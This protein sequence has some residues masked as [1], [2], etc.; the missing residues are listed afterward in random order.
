MASNSEVPHVQEFILGNARKKTD[1]PLNVSDILSNNIN[2][3]IERFRKKLGYDP[4]RVAPKRIMGVAGFSR[5]AVDGRVYFNLHEP[6]ME[7]LR[8]SIGS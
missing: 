4:E 5:H 2:V 3:I 8:D 6:V 7:A 1:P